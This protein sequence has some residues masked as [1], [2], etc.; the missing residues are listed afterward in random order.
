MVD[1]KWQS[2]MGNG[3]LCYDFVMQTKQRAHPSKLEWGQCNTFALSPGADHAARI[4]ADGEIVTAIGKVARR[5][6]HTTQIFDL[7]ER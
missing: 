6:F 2:K 1:Q 4:P 5:D 3:S 7:F